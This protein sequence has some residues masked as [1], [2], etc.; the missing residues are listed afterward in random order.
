MP[1]LGLG[2]FY[3]DNTLTNDD[4]E[5]GS[6]TNCHG[7]AK[8]NLEYSGLD[9]RKVYFGCAR[10]NMRPSPAPSIRL[11]IRPQYVNSV[12]LWILTQT[13]YVWINGNSA[14]FFEI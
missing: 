13:K 8:L 4:Y 3:L 12:T 7:I 5:M 11:S 1:S 2:L 9:K 14:L 10:H 6:G